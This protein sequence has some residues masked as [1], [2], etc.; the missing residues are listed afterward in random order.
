VTADLEVVQ[1]FTAKDRCD[2]C[3]AQARTMALLV[4]GNILLFCGHHHKE[5]RA[6]LEAAG[7]EIVEE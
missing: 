5:Y 1:L 6:G 7:A 4:T 2:R 3:G